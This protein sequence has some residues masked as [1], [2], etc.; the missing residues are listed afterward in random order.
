[1]WLAFLFSLSVHADVLETVEVRYTPPPA[2]PSCGLLRHREA[3]REKVVRE[4]AELKGREQ[5]R[6]NHLLLNKL[7]MPDESWHDESVYVQAKFKISDG[8]GMEIDRLGLDG[9]YFSL[10]APGLR[11]ESYSFQTPSEISIFMD[12]EGHLLVTYQTYLNV[13]CLEKLEV[14]VFEWVHSDLA[15]GRPNRRVWFAGE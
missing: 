13:L 5:L 15:P 8:M 1:M 12:G 9:I 6:V 10:D 3:A 2:A 4:H 7:F 11:W 14:P